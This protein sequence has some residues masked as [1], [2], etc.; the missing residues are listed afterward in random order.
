MGDLAKN[1][2]LRLKE[3]LPLRPR[4]PAPHHG[5]VHGL[6]ADA[7]DWREGP[8]RVAEDLDPEVGNPIAG[9][10]D[11]GAAD[12]LPKVLGADAHVA[13]D[14]ADERGEQEASGGRTG[15]V[16]HGAPEVLNEFTT[17]QDPLIAEVG[18]AASAEGRDRSP[19]PVAPEEA[20]ALELRPAAVGH[21]EGDEFPICTP[22]AREAGAELGQD[23]SGGL[24]RARDTPEEG[25]VPRPG[26][27]IEDP[28][29]R[30][31]VRPE[32]VQAQVADELQEVRVLFHYDRLVPVLEEV[33]DP[34]V[35]PVESAPH[36]GV[37][38][39]RMAR[40]KG[41]V[42]VRTRRWA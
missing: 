23:L 32:R 25:A 4:L 16:L 2:K 13:A 30:D 21:A 20:A 24:P 18:L 10:G 3:A 38:R 14:P 8:A 6:R 37:K 9:A 12:T 1:G 29:I 15:G 35:A 11:I 28:E 39:L 5:L 41:R 33:P 36:D 22:G 34:L 31:D 42:P 40:A 19:L 26:I 17:P 27:P 7:E